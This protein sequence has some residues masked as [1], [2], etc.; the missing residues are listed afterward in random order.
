MLRVQT[1]S[2]KFYD[3]SGNKED[4]T[5]KGTFYGPAFY[6]SVFLG[7][8]LLISRAVDLLFVFLPKHWLARKGIMQKLITP[9][10][11]QAESR[12]KR[13]ASYK[14][15]EMVN[16]ALSCRPGYNNNNNSDS[17]TSSSIR[18]SAA[19]RRAASSDHSTSSTSPT[20][21]ALMN[22]N[23]SLVTK[24]P[25]GGIVWAWKRVF[26]GKIYS[27]EGIWLHGE[28]KHIGNTGW[29]TLVHDDLPH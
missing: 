8:Y 14:V 19:S 21:K 2:S 26:T 15:L 16:N 12:M 23:L 27:E 25:A 5:P 24:E 17:S 13:G 7:F 1:Y 6:I 29:H 22:Y 4:G 20:E 11:I 18:R 10:N 9:G 3:S 28:C